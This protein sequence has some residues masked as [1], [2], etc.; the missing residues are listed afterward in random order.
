MVS[1]PASHSQTQL[2][3]LPSWPLPRISY[4]AAALGNALLDLFT[5]PQ[6]IARSQG[7]AQPTPWQGPWSVKGP[8]FTAFVRPLPFSPD[9]AFSFVPECLGT[10]VW[11]GH[12]W[13][14][15]LNSLRPL[16]VHPALRPLPPD[17]LTHMVPPEVRLAAVELLLE[18]L[19][20]A[21]EGLL[22]DTVTLRDMRFAEEQAPFLCA[23]AALTLEVLMDAGEGLRETFLCCLTPRQSEGGQALFHTLPTLKKG[24]DS[25]PR[26]LDTALQG[27]AVSVAVL[28]GYVRLNVDEVATL[29]PGDILLPDDFPA[30]RGR[31]LLCPP[32]TTGTPPHSGVHTSAGSGRASNSGT[33]SGL[34]RAFPCTVTGNTLTVD[35]PL[36]TLSPEHPMTQDTTDIPE[37]THENVQ[38]DFLTS[39]VTDLLRVDLRFELER[40]SM[41]VAEIGALVPG[42]VLTLT[43]DTASPVTLIAGD[44]VLGQGRL[45]DVDG[46]MGVQITT[47]ATSR[48]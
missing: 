4:F 22:H 8:G 25:L 37:N 39:T 45:V 2:P 30:A 35:G 27:M 24:T 36:V 16:R 38:K 48:S 31:L 17:K 32:M 11:R 20:R 14:W 5:Q 40:R 7:A 23:K 10:L 13:E 33:S 15:A 12:I 29:A 26:M 34:V 21:L 44:T 9:V 1:R 18:P 28:A 6:S 19:V 46:V 43:A 3:P 42:S 47:L 41:T